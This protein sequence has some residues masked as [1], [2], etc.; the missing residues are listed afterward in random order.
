V[1]F[2]KHPSALPWFSCFLI[3]V[4]SIIISIFNPHQFTDTVKHQGQNQIA[5]RG[6]EAADPVPDKYKQRKIQTTFTLPVFQKT[7][8]R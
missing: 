3:G 2:F 7:V 8:R 1:F 6:N 4:Y 5:A